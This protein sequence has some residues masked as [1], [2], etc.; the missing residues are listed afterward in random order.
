MGGCSNP[1]SAAASTPCVFTSSSLAAGR[2][3]RLCRACVRRPP[4]PP[5][6]GGWRRRGLLA[7]MARPGQD[8]YASGVRQEAGDVRCGTRRGWPQTGRLLMGIRLGAHGRLEAP[9]RRPVSALLTFLLLAAVVGCGARQT[10]QASV[11]P[12]SEGESSAQATVAATA[13]EPATHPSG[14]GRAGLIHR[15]TLS[16]KR[17]IR[18]EPQ[19][20]SVRVGESLTWHSDLKSPMTIYVSPGVFA[21]ESFR[22]R[23]GATISTGPAR[24]AGRYSFWTEPAACR[25]APRGVLLA[26]PGVRVQETFYASTSGPR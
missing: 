13:Q 22:V 12:Q 23:P 4:M 26:G 3:R 18:F 7:R 19:W 9:A 1:N 11:G 17:C 2:T 24:A 14:R 21:K 16:D 25:D 6:H 15:I 20:M 10:E 8:E 5:R